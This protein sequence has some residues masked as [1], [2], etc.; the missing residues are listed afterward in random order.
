MFR[1]FL[2]LLLTFSHLYLI[3][4]GEIRNK[5]SLDYQLLWG[6][7]FKAFFVKTL[8][9]YELRI[10]LVGGLLSI[11]F[12]DLDFLFIF[13]YKGTWTFPC[14][15][16]NINHFRWRVNVGL[17]CFFDITQRC[18]K[19]FLMDILLLSAHKLRFGDFLSRCNRRVLGTWI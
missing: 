1:I 14:K 17:R 3:F 10:W 19:L 13:I 15:G 9:N 5:S 4:W 18:L 16:Y 11:N 8:W 2:C 6:I 7:L 12:V